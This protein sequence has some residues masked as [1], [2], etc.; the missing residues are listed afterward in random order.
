MTC[1][2][3]QGR[4]GHRRRVEI[5]GR[6]T[7]RPPANQQGESEGVGDI[8]QGNEDRHHEPEQSQAQTRHVVAH[9]DGERVDQVGGPD[10]IREPDERDREP[11]LRPAA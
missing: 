5:E 6:W 7:L 3:C 2:Q 4:E 1:P 10:D 9:A 8:Q 11:G